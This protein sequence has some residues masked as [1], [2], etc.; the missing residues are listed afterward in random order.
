ML[1]TL[2][3]VQYKDEL[4]EVNWEVANAA[5]DKVLSEHLA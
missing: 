3:P 5:V 2:D 1:S 4:V